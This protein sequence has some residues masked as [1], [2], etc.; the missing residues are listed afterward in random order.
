MVLSKALLLDKGKAGHL[1]MMSTPLSLT[2]PK[3]ESLDTSPAY[4]IDYI[5]TLHDI[6]NVVIEDWRGCGKP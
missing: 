3:K 4:Y 1:V 6:K 2:L 5:D